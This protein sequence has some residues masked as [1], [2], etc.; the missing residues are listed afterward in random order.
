MRQQSVVGEAGELVLGRRPRHRDGAFGQRRGAVGR[1]FIGRHHRLTSADE[2][3]QAEVVAL[4]ALGFFRVP[5]AHLDGERHRAHRDRIRRVGTGRVCGL[6]E[7][8]GAIGQRAQVQ[9]GI[10]R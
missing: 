4:G 8:V 6:N 5:V 7:P 9:E 3:A 10:D 1:D 2:D